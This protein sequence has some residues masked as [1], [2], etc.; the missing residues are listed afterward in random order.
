M[1]KDF[2]WFIRKG[3]KSIDVLVDPA[4]RCSGYNV[5]PRTLDPDNRFDFDEVTAYAQAHPDKELPAWEDPAVPT[6]DQQWARIQ[7]D[8]A[9]LETIAE[10][11]CHLYR[12]MRCRILG[13]SIPGQ[14]DPAR[15][16]HDGLTV[17]E[18]T[19]RYLEYVGDRD[20]IAL[21]CLEGKREA[22]SYIR[23]LVGG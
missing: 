11:R 7:E 1:N 22:K 20:D 9:G 23:T 6:E 15:P 19:A 12:M 17:D 3:P 16:F 14:R 21:A 4:T 2:G 8:L 18:M 5:V 13:D 10:K